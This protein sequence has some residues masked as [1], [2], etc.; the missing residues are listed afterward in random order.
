MHHVV[1]A[2]PEVHQ[3]VVQALLYIRKSPSYH[4]AVRFM[5]PACRLLRIEFPAQSFRIKHSGCG[6]AFI[7]L[8]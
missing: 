8:A 3:L 4:S 2:L 6:I 1:N 7:L 5:M